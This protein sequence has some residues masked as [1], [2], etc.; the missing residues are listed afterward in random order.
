[1]G[2]VYFLNDQVELFAGF[3]QGLDISEPGRA[4]SQVDSAAQIR[5]EPAVTD[6]Y[7]LGMRRFG[8]RWDG[9]ITVFPSARARTNPQPHP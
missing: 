5:L 2:L 3:S 1:V 7:D 4:A 9:S 8:D 6:S